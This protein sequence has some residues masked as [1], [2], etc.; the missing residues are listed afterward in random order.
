MRTEQEIREFRDKLAKEKDNPKWL[1]S[2]RD[3]AQH[4]YGILEW[5]LNEGEEKK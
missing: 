4:C 2:T 3:M 1:Q 5:V